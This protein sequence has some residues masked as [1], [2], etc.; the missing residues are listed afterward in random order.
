MKGGKRVQPTRPNRINS[1]IRATE[2]RLTGV[3]GEQLGIVSLREALEKAEE[4]GV[5][6][7]EISPNAEPPV[8]RIMDYGKFLYEKSKSSKEQKKKQKVIQVKEI[9]F[10]PGTDDGDYQVKLRNLIR[11]LEEGD[12]AKI[13]LRFRGREMAHQQIGMEVLNRVRKDLCDD[14]DLAIVES[15]PSKIE[16]RQMIMV[17]APKKKQ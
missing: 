15:F 14:L 9:K 2:V 1:E 4:A 7:V 8:C 5:D 17:L 6:L 3:E 10:R 16:G 13:T 12:K 11:F